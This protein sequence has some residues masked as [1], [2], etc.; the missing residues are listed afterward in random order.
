MSTK[1]RL[2][3]HNSSRK[4]ISG[5]VSQAPF[6]Y[7]IGHAADFASGNAPAK[8]RKKELM[9]ERIMKNAF[10]ASS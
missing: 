10:V 9:R 7:N 2:G 8:S 3:N 5:I 4:A 6:C 1:N